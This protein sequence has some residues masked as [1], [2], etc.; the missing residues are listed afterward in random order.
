MFLQNPLWTMGR[1]LRPFERPSQSTTARV[2]WQLGIDLSQFWGLGFEVMLPAEAVSREGCL[3]L[4]PHTVQ[5]A[6]ELPGVS[7]FRA[8]IPF[9][10]A[11]L[12]RLNHLPES[13]QPNTVTSR[14]PYS[15]ALACGNRC[16]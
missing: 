5:R 2:A 8:V 6:K 14:P 1:S 9:T 15:L 12:L 10:R 13:P 3:S 16:A 7:C 4:C 11:P